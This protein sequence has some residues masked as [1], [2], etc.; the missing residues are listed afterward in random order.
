MENEVN[1][2]IEWIKNYVES[3]G[4]NGVVIGNS[5]GKDSAVVTGLC[6][7]ALGNDKVL[8]IA[9]PCSSIQEDIADAKLVADAFDVQMLTMDLTNTYST[10]TSSIEQEIKTSIPNYSSINIKPRLRMTTLY[11]IAQ[12]K[13]FLVAGTGNLCESFVGYTTKWGDNASDFNPL[14]EFSVREVLEI[15]KIIGVPSKILEKAPND[16]LGS[17]SDEDKLG[18]KYS[19]IEDYI[20]NGT[21]GN[22]EADLKIEKLHKASQHKRDKIPVYKR[23]NF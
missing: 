15:G 2:V 20:K 14:A 1:L 8:T 17:G 12:A 5:G 11:A 9:M 22:A 4:A 10:L 16:G 13:G 18:V 23:I 19:Q 3:V 21:C 6:T 7:K